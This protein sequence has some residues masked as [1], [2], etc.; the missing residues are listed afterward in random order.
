MWVDLVPINDIIARFNFSFGRLHSLIQLMGL[1]PK[2]DHAHWVP[3]PAQI[4]EETAAIRSRWSEEERLYR[5]SHI[6]D[7]LPPSLLREPDDAI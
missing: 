1:P 7:P 4:A 6:T 2:R 5:A 3:S